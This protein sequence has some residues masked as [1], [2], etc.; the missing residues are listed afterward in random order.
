MQPHQRALTVSRI[1]LGE[2]GTHQ[3]S[4]PFIFGAFASS[5]KRKKKRK[6]SNFQVQPNSWQTV[7]LPQ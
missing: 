6:R 3:L 4:F 7:T 5:T 2:K 1:S